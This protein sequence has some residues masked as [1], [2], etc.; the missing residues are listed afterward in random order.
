[1]GPPSERTL[2]NLTH[3]NEDDNLFEKSEF[4]MKRPESARVKI[5]GR[6]NIF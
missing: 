3:D 4:L 2:A 6:D 1:M 5:P